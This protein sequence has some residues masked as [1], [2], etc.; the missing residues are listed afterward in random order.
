M[1]SNFANLVIES[2]MKVNVAFLYI[3]RENISVKLCSK[4]VDF[5][6]G[7]NMLLHGSAFEQVTH[8]SATH[9]G[10]QPTETILHNVHAALTQR[11]SVVVVRT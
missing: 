5:S 1:L 2:S 9:D 7:R 11:R 10:L 8:V 6:K 3:V 4:F